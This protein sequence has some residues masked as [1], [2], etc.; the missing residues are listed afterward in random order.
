M[1][2]P[3]K[4]VFFL[5]VFSGRP[6]STLMNLLLLTPDDF[7]SEDQVRLTGRRFKH[8]RHV[9]RATIGDRLRVGVANGL[10]GEG[11]ITDANANFLTMQVTLTEIPPPA[12]PL[13][14]LL[15]LPRPKM[16]KRSLQ[17]LTSLGVKTIVLINS[18]RVEKSFWQSPWLRPEVIEAQCILGLE[19]AR[20]TVMPTVLLEKRFKPFVEDR[21]PAMA[22]NKTALVA[23][24]AGANLCPRRLNTSAV[25]AIGPEG[26][27]IPYEVKKL[28]E[29]GFQAIHLGTRI[30]RVETV[31]TALVSKLYD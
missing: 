27:F 14:V 6:V 1:D 5:P 16:L 31:V 4:V 23:H 11:I 20:D 3:R 10:M 22:S 7:V 9:H 28:E 12:L 21:L 30:L 19:Q 18:Y 8:I 2:S 17:H 26:G 24:P 15:A 25:I 29:A 13:T